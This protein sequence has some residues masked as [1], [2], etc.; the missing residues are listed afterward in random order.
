MADHEGS[1]FVDGF[2][3]DE[4]ETEETSSENIT[5]QE[6]E[7][8]NEETSTEEETE[9]TQNDHDEDDSG[10]DGGKQITDKGTKLDPN[11]QSAVHQQL[12]NAKREVEDYR[13]IMQDPVQLKKY[14]AELE[15]DLGGEQEIVATKKDEEEFVTDPDK[16]EN[17]K[18]LRSYAKYLEKKQSEQIDSIKKE[19]SK[20]REVSAFKET[21]TRISSEIEQVQKD[22]PE[23]RALNA[24]GTKN[25]DFDPALEKEVAD[26]YEEL[27]FDPKRKVFMGK[28]SIKKVADRIMRVRHL[29]EANGSKRAQTVIVDRRN[30]AVK[31]NSGGGGTPD[32]SQESPAQTIANRIARANKR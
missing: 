18:D 24:D 29:G 27:D 6:D 28:V 21:N 19:I 13:A 2:D 15:A 9:E 7:T 22:Y 14:I 11:P 26:L 17:T 10:E 5:N 12:A 1:V 25:P 31:S 20:E 23:L 4:N 32:E 8:Q 16:I 30:G 3:Q